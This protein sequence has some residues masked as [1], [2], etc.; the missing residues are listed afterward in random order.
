MNGTAVELFWLASACFFVSVVAVYFFFF[1][2]ILVLFQLVAF[3]L[4]AIIT[5]AEIVMREF[6][7]SL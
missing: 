3:N 4:A 6:T 2:S 7:L 5:A 1:A